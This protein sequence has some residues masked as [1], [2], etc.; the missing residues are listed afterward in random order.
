MPVKLSVVIITFNEA[1]NI[2]R[3]L[4][5]VEKLADDIVVV[6]S[7]S[8]DNTAEICAQHGVRFVSRAFTGYV[9]Q[10]NFANSQAAYPHI[11]SLDADE[12]VSPELE[13]SIL[14][15]KA[16]WQLAGYYLVRLTNYCGSW[17][18]HGGWYPDKKLRLYNREQGQWAGLLLHEVYQVQP[19]Q[20]TGLLKGDLLHYSFYTLDDHLKQIDHFTTI[21]CQELK[22]KGKKPGLWPMLVKPPFKFF[23]MYFLKMGWRD[24]FAGF[25]VAV[26]SG[27]AVFVKYA[28]LYWAHR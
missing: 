11:L 23:Q 16:N 6:D 2:G 10:K 17:I 26:L 20:A 14:T 21:A 25:C 18:R 8:T 27:Y 1:R 7:Y 12:V 28:K 13:K 22:L 4:E 9:D 5:S 19:N 15:I 3:C 24:G